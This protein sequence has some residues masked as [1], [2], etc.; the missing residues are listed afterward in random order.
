[1]TNEYKLAPKVP[2]KEMISDGCLVLHRGV[3]KTY[4]AMT[5]DAPT[6]V[7][8]DLKSMVGKYT[9][10]PSYK[11]LEANIIHKFIREVEQKHG[12]IYAV[13]EE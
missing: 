12:K 13:K 9:Y 1:M 4:N 5:K 7:E 10:E 6:L 2:T 8:V 11:N 3:V